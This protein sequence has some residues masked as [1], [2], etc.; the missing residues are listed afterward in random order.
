M[1][2]SVS[3]LNDIQINADIDDAEFEPAKIA[4]KKF[5]DMLR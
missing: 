3:F 1:K 4:N 2:V 5:F